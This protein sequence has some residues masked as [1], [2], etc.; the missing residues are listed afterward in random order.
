MAHAIDP[1]CGMTVDQQKAAAT[2]D[3]QG[4][5][6]YFCSQG[7]VVRFRS[8]PVRY[9]SG[10]H[11]PMHLVHDSVLPSRLH[12]IAA[13]A[14]SAQPSDKD[15]P[16]GCCHGHKASAHVHPSIVAATPGAI[17]TC[18]MHPEVQQRGPGSCPKCGMALELESPIA[19]EQVE[20][21]CP[22]HPEV[23]SDK[24]GNCPKCGMALEP[25]T[26]TAEATNPELA[27]MTRRFWTSA[28]LT[29]PL[30][31]LAMSRMFFADQL[32]S[33]LSPR[34]LSFVDSP[35]RRPSSSGAAGPSLCGCGNRS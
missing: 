8:N 17:Y 33:W 4:K 34:A 18:P 35:S 29:V 28:V 2:A 14:S 7:C 25:R 23:V 1:V 9:L 19:D 32:H 22:M 27:D 11:E 16:C 26:I 10:S 3:H 6:Y 12:S 21:I 13:A 5:T 30:V 15:E 31:A 24:P 20:Y